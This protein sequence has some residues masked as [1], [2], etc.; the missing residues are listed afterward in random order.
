MSIM[1]REVSDGR[2]T[3]MKATVKAVMHLEKSIIEISS[4]AIPIKAVT[5]P[6]RHKPKDT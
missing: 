6:A 2:R 3:S 1:K 4:T 5:I